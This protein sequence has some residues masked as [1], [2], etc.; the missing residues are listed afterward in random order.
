MAEAL[1]R[2]KNVRKVYRM[3]D[4]R[5]I[6]LDNISLEIH[7]GEIVCFL[8]TSGSGKSTFLNMVAGLEKPTR[9]EVWIGNIPIHKL[10]EEQVTLFRQKN[11]GFIFQAYHLMPMLTAIENVSLPLIFRSVDK[12]KRKKMAEEALAAVGLK[13]YENRK[14]TQMS[15][16]Q[17]Q[18][19]GIARALVGTPKIIFAD[20]PTGNL[21]THTTKE[22]MELIIKQVKDHKQTLIMVTHDRSIANYADKVVTIQDGNIIK[23]E[24]KGNED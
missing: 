11:I 4:E 3:G 14:P 20:E 7:K 16:G 17:Q 18:R 22:V 2:V 13:G 1:I 24:V 5:V 10:N 6:A 21:D 8:G 23:V 12:K 19:V 15:G 9:G